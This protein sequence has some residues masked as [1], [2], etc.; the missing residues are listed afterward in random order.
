MDRKRHFPALGHV[1]GNSVTI[2]VSGWKIAGKAQHVIQKEFSLS[3]FGEATRGLWFRGSSTVGD[4]YC[5][6]STSEGMYLL[7]AQQNSSTE[8]PHL[9]WGFARLVGSVSQEI[10]FIKTIAAGINFVAIADSRTSLFYFVIF[11]TPFFFRFYIKGFR[12]WISDFGFQISYFFQILIILCFFF[13]NLYF[14]FQNFDFWFQIL[15]FFRFWISDFEY[16][17]L[18][19]SD[20]W[21]KILD[22]LRFWISDFFPIFVYLFFL[23]RFR[24]LSDFRFWISDIGFQILFLRFF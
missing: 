15:D 8:E 19:F 17:I 6:S 10:N 4:H 20:F 2:S 14:G 16:Q 5:H 21:Y 1:E 9:N 3:R 13:L 23:F 18:I 11:V 24:I 12:F 7:F 22:F